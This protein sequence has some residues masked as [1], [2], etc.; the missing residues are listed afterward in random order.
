MPPGRTTKSPG[1]GVGTSVL[2]GRPSAR[3]AAKPPSSTATWPWPAQ[4]SSHHARAAIDPL[5]AS[6]TT[7]G[8]SPRTPAARS[9]RCSAVRVGQRVAPGRAGRRGQL[10]VQV[11]VHRVRQVPAVV[12]VAPG[13]AAQPPPH[14]QHDGWVR[15]VRRRGERRRTTSRERSRTHCDEPVPGP[16][17]RRQAQVA[18]PARPLQ[19]S[20]RASD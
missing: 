3:H 8:R 2:T 14:V 5:S 4:R 15:A 6:Y 20:T 13:R 7:T 1:S 16:G 17:R 18:H 10:G 19:C 9:A 12:L 11:D